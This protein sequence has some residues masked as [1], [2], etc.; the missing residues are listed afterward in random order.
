[1]GFYVFNQDK[2]RKNETDLRFFI[3]LT[4]TI[5]GSYRGSKSW[6]YLG[7]QTQLSNLFWF[8]IKQTAWA[9]ARNMTGQNRDKQHWLT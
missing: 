9:S 2:G 3:E 5:K 6:L 7:L 1:M 4:F 8:L